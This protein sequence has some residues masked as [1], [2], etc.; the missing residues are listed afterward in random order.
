[1]KFLALLLMA[2]VVASAITVVLSLMS[3]ICDKIT[4]EDEDNNEDLEHEDY[5]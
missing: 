4:N 3:Y 2:I 5:D 1:M